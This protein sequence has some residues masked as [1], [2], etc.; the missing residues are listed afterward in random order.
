MESAFKAYHQAKEMYT[1]YGVRAEADR[2]TCKEIEEAVRKD[3]EDFL[4]LI[5][6]AGEILKIKVTE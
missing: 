5:R 1:S 4:R 3:L 6:W 2:E